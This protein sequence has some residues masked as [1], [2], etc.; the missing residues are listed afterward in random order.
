MYICGFRGFILSCCFIH[1]YSKKKIFSVGARVKLRKI[2]LKCT[3]TNRFENVNGLSYYAI[4]IH[5]SSPDFPNKK[6]TT[7][8]THTISNAVFKMSSS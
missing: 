8:L 5:I 4:S 3:Y 6:N 1:C 7:T 2:D